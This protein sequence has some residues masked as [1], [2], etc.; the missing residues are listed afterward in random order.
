ML[1]IPAKLLS[2]FHECSGRSEMGTPLITKTKK[3]ANIYLLKVKSRYTRKRCEVCSK[4]TKTP[5]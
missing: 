5:E 1:A 4:L 3:T 2:N